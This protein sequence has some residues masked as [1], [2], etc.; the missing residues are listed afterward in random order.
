MKRIIGR[1]IVGVAVATAAVGAGATPALAGPPPCSG[2][3]CNGGDGA[4][5]SHGDAICALLGKG[6]FV[7]TPSAHTNVHC[8]L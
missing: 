8:H 3:G 7:H 5:V 6:T 2:S 4:T 1:L